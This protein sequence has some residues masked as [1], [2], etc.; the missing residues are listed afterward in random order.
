MK[1]LTTIRSNKLTRTLKKYL[2]VVERFQPAET[3][4]VFTR[5]QFVCDSAAGVIKVLKWSEAGGHLL[6][7]LQ[8]EQDGHCTNVLCGPVNSEFLTS[9][10]LTNLNVKG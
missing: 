1:P 8:T 5:L 3:T 9:L 4:L 7:S 6:L 2:K 10:E